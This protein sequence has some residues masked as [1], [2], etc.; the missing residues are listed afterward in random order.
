MSARYG[1]GT[2][3]SRRFGDTPEERQ[4]TLDDAGDVLAPGLIAQEEPGRRVDHAV[5]RGLVE[6]SNGRFLLVEGLGRVPGL[7]LSLDR[8]HPRP[9]APRLAPPPPHPDATARLTP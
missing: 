6:P 5:E 2:R 4:G 7:H 8:A 9:P 3:C 1:N